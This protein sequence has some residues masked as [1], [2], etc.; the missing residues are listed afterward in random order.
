MTKLQLSVEDDEP[1][2][3]LPFEKAFVQDLLGMVAF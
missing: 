2:P 3:M 1:H